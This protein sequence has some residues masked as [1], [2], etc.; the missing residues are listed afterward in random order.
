[1]NQP[2]DDVYDRL[3][4]RKIINAFGSETHLGGSRLAPE[5]TAAMAQAATSFVDLRELLA[6]SGDYVAELIGVEAAYIT[7]GAAAG[8]VLATAACVAGDDPARIA[9]L[10]DTREMPNRV[11][12]HRAHR[13]NFDQAVRQVGV[14]LV[15]FGYMNETRPWQ[16]EAALDDQTAA[17]LYVVEMSYLGTSLS[18]EKVVEIAHGHGIPVI[19][20]AAPDLPPVSNLHHFNDL[21]ADLVVFSGG[22]DIEGPQSSGLILGRRDLIRKCALNGSPNYSIGRP[23]KVCKEEIIGLVVALERYLAQDREAEDAQWE[24]IMAYWVETLG[25]LPGVHAWRVCPVPVPPGLSPITIPRAYVGWDANAVNLTVDEAMQELYEGDPRVAV[26][27]DSTRNALVLL[28]EVLA[29]GEE[30]VVA[31]RISELL[32]AHKVPS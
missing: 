12:V 31:Q 5:V 30:Q 9:R 29:P 16:L 23:M 27:V 19:V 18:L 17:V 28:G 32:S 4:V 13:N 1:M 11:A 6:K 21:C 22:K 2:S 10:P 25:A 14:E 20:D 3:G 8:L 26:D 7:S 24:A 15:E